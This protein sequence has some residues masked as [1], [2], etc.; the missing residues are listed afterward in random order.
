VLAIQHLKAAIAR[1]F[2]AFSILHTDPDLDAIRGRPEYA[3]LLKDID[4]AAK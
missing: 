2:K 4:V 1:G 3:T